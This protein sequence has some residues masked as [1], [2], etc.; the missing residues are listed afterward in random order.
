MR[1]IVVVSGKGGTGKTTVCASFAALAHQQGQ[2]TV[3][4]DLDVDV[5]DMRPLQAL[6]EAGIAVYYNANLPTVADCLNAFAAGK[7]VPFGP[8]HLCRGGCVSKR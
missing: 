8:G 7:L 5:P 3:L 2:K 4:C 1:E 6:Q